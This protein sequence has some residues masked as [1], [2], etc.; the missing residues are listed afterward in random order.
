MKTTVTTLALATLIILTPLA[1]T[2]ADLEKMAVRQSA[3]KFI[4][5][6]MRQLSGMARGQS[7]LN[8]PYVAAVGSSIAIIGDSLSLWFDDLP[9]GYPHADSE[10]LPVIAANRDAFL[11][12]AEKMADAGR[13]MASAP[14]ALAASFQSLSSTCRSCHSQFRM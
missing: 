10:A 13:A 11:A 14:D 3:M 6:Q 8:A 4:G 7:D 12:Q 1:T 9:E 5:A 2:P